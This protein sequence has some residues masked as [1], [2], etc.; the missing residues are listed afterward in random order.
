M[1]QP[2]IHITGDPN[3]DWIIFAVG[4]L[5]ALYWLR[6]L[7]LARQGARLFIRN[8]AKAMIVFAVLA[9]AIPL[10]F[11]I[12]PAQ[13][14]FWAI[15]IAFCFFIRWQSAKRSRYVSAKTRREVIAR[16]LKGEEFDSSKHHIDHV[17]PHARGGSNTSDNLRVI[18]KEKNLQK[19]A[20]RPG[21]RDMW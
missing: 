21:L 13:S 6:A 9:M 20:K 4:F 2:P 12:E 5:G 1:A 17:W 14:Q 10:A 3:L 7:R 15:F 8:L 19:G 18:E 11:H 16:D